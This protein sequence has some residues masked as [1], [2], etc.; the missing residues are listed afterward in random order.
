MKKLENEFT[1]SA[2]R[3]AAFAY[4]KRQYWWNYYGSWGG[5]EPNAPAEVREAYTLKNLS[6]RWAWVGTVVHETIERILRDLQESALKNE[7]AFVRPQV[8]PA[9][10]VEGVTL[11][12]R[13]DWRQSKRGFYR[14]RPKKMFG[15]AE[16]EYG[17]EV[18]GDEW[19]ALNTKA[20]RA[21]GDFLTSDLW[22]SIRESNPRDWLP[23]EQ[24]DQFEFEGTPVWAVLDFAR[25]MPDGRIEIY[26]WKTGEP[27]A[28]AYKSQLGVYAM[29]MEASRGV[30]SQRV[31]TNLVFLGDD[32]QVLTLPSTEEDI[33]ETRRTMRASIAAMRTRLRDKQGNVAMREDFAMT[34]DRVKCEACVYRRLC[35]RP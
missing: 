7:L 2:S 17:D 15:L 6:N 35:G 26:D 34:E 18:S 5:W 4:C 28:E 8:E 22:A 13:E 25:T 10:E 19:R 3:A 30:P 29:Y 31:T 11:R 23:I 14:D 32:M 12:M 1:W 16:H 21:I 27:K 20:K 33:K 24:L 9:N